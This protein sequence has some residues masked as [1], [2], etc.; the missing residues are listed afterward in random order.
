VSSERSRQIRK[1][2]KNEI[3]ELHED[4]R[5][6]V[7][8]VLDDEKEGIANPYEYIVK[9]LEIEWM[10]SM[11]HIEHFEH[12]ENM[13]AHIGHE[14]NNVIKILI[15]H[16]PVYFDG[17]LEPFNKILNH[18]SVEGIEFKGVK[19]TFAYS[20]HGLEEY[21]LTFHAHNS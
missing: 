6:R 20:I 15:A 19:Y 10:T 16:R 1:R 12:G 5:K 17:V 21:T 3:H 9:R 4:L 8:H 7:M 14:G 2:Y 11:S 13:G 18:L